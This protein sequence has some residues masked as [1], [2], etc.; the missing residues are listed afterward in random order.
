MPAK[1]TG[2]SG[3]ERATAIVGDA[4]RQAGLPSPLL[5]RLPEADGLDHPL[6]D[7]ADACRALPAWT[8][9]A[10]S[11][12]SSKPGLRPNSPFR[13]GADGGAKRRLSLRPR[14]VQEVIV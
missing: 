11:I 1:P 3:T 10:C 14:M 5:I 9:G 8:Y 12:T 13:F 6:G 2:V 7:F 4:G